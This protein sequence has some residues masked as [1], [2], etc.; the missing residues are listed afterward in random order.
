MHRTDNGGF[1][2]ESICDYCRKPLAD[3]RLMVEG[4]QGSLV[5]VQCLTV[6]YTEVVV[7]GGGAI[8]PADATCT[9]CLESREEPM[10]Q[11][12][13]PPNCWICRRCIKQTAGLMVKDPD[14]KFTKPTTT[15]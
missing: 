10:W 15:A 9:M 8:A 11:S 4:H 3:D 13:V 1:V 5:C 12:P 6:A 14:F 2:T 7:A